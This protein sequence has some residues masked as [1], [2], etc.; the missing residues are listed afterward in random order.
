LSL[1]FLKNN[2]LSVPLQAVVQQGLQSITRFN[3]NKVYNLQIRL[4][5][6]QRLKTY[7]EHLRLYDA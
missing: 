7:Q 3:K 1:L 5:Q 4:P 6:A 2:N